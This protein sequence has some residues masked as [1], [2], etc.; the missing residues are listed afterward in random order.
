MSLQ[1]NHIVKTFGKGE[2]ET[3]VLKDIDITVEPGEFII[4][5][6]ASGSGKSTL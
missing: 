2:T 3:K 5:S 6:G 1:V 4:L